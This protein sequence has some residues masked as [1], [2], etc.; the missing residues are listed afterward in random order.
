MPYP[1]N[2]LVLVL[3]YLAIISVGEPPEGAIP[4]VLIYSAT[5]GSV[6]IAS[7]FCFL[8]VLPVS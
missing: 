8:T 6:P 2:L 4:R 7:P 1:L 5:A 3:L